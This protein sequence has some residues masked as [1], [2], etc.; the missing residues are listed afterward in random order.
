MS[1]SAKG[2]FKSKEHCLNISYAR[3]GQISPFKD[4]H[5]SDETKLKMRNA[6]LGKKQTEE[7]INKRRKYLIGNKYA[8]GNTSNR[9]KKLSE[10][11]KLKISEA[12]K[13]TIP[14]N[15]KHIRQYDLQ[16]NFIRE[17]N[18]ATHA[19]KDLLINRSNINACLLG[20]YRQANGYVW[21]YK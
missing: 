3:K 17:W 2:K 14:W 21:N 12:R 10:E 4:K 7:T 13:G 20:K 15:I 5:H 16:G 8:C 9:G 6:K 18:S 11:T 1:I 19:A